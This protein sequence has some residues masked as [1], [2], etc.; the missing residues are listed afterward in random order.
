MLDGALRLAPAAAIAIAVGLA[1]RALLL[2][3]LPGMHLAAIVLR[4]TVLCTTGIAV[5]AA[6]ARLFGLRELVEMEGILLRKLRSLQP[7]IDLWSRLALG[8]R[9]SRAAERAGRPL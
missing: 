1:T 7:P 3:L 4:A 2:H 6:L 5:Y 9:T 8:P